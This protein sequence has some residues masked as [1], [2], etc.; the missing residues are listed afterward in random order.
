MARARKFKK[1]KQ[2]T[3]LDEMTPL[4]IANAWIYCH[5]KPLHPGWWG[6]WQLHLLSY[7]IH[8][9]ALFHADNNQQEE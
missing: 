7:Y 4:F 8:R 1:G 5:D 3:S 6:S 2:I 9:G